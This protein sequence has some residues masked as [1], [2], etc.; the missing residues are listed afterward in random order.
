MKKSGKDMNMMRGRSKNRTCKRRFKPRYPSF[1]K[2]ASKHCKKKA[3]KTLPIKHW[4]Q[5]ILQAIHNV[6]KFSL[7][8]M[9]A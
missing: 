3:R 4:V 9:G 1:P 2:Q 6:D 5:T 8:D 7:Q